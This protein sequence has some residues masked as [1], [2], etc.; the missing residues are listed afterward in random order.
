[1][2]E[3]LGPEAGVERDKH[4][5]ISDPKEA[6]GYDPTLL[7]EILSKFGVS[8]LMCSTVTSL[9]ATATLGATMPPCAPASSPRS[10]REQKKANKVTVAYSH[11]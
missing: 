7:W 6:T 8:S 1:M 9:H 10:L 4:P 2:L 11:L 3:G 5:S